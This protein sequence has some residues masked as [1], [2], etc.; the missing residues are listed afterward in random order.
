MVLIPSVEE[1]VMVAPEVAVVMSMA[2][3]LAPSWGARFSIP[4]RSRRGGPYT[5]TSRPEG[6]LVIT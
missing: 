5:T 6:R 1:P 2:G 3:T 4:D